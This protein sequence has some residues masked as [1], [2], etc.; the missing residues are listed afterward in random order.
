MRFS[1][2]E[3]LVEDVMLIVE[4]QCCYAIDGQRNWI[5]LN[6]IAGNMAIVRSLVIIWSS[7]VLANLEKKKK[8]ESW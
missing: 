1:I 3:E 5:E 2:D 8:V 4:A 7:I 6:W